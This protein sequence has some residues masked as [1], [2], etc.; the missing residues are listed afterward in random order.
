MGSGAN[1]LKDGVEGPR[2]SGAEHEVTLDNAGCRK[3]KRASL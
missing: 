3:A 1:E 2:I